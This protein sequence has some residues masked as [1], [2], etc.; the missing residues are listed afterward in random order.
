MANEGLEVVEVRPLGVALTESS[1]KAVRKGK[2]LQLVRLVVPAGT[3][4]PTRHRSR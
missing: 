1:T 3:E 2:M 4:V